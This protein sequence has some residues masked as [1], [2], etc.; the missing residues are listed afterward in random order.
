LLIVYLPFLHEPFT[1]YALPLRDWLIVGGLAVTII[2]VLETAKWMV[3][4]GWLGKSDVEN[5]SATIER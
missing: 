4:K 3:R 2:P 1:T 5:K